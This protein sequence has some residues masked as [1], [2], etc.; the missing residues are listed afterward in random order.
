MAVP[1][2]S[3]L[4]HLAA[5]DLEGFRSLSDATFWQERGCGIACLLMIL[6]ALRPAAGSPRY[7]DMVYEGLE[8]NAYCDRGWIHD[9][10]VR[11]ACDHG[12]SGEA[13]RGARAKDVADQ[14]RSNRP[15]IVS[16]T[17]A[18]EGGKTDESGSRVLKGGHLAVV[19]GYAE[20]SGEV[21]EFLVHHPSSWPRYNWPDRWVDGLSF[22][23]SFS[24]NFM[25]FGAA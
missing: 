14:I 8:K 18:F 10:L 22:D 19:F 16:I 5:A 21:R 9:G 1:F 6:G 13:F 2:R 4:V 23:R 11:L 12:V 3:Q 15:C 24:G 7:G 17:A 20:E 25:A